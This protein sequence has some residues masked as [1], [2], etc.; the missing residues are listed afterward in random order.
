M[1]VRLHVLLINLIEHDDHGEE[2]NRL[3]ES[4]SLM[5]QGKLFQRVAPL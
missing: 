2:L 4:D 1:E 5:S 3:I